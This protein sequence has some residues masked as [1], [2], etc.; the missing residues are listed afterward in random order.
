[1]L[2]ASRLRACLLRG[3]R[4]LLSDEAPHATSWLASRGSTVNLLGLFRGCATDVGRRYRNSQLDAGLCWR[5]YTDG[6][7]SRRRAVPV[8]TDAQR[9]PLLGQV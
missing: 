6:G 8:R 7:G 3:D 5:V 4:L 9:L 1:M 2:R